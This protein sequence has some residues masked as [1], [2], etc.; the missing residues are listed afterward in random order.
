MGFING[1]WMW[2]V[3]GMFSALVPGL[4]VLAYLVLKVVSKEK[5]NPPGK[6]LS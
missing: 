2:F 4:L 1:G 5:H 6:N 3:L